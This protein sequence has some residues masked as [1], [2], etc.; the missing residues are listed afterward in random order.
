MIKSEI[1]LARYARSDPPR[2]S[3][4]PPFRDVFVYIDESIPSK[5]ERLPARDE[6][7]PR[8]IRA[9][10]PA[11]SFAGCVESTFFE[12][13]MLIDQPLQ[14]GPRDS[15]DPRL[16]RRD[17]G[18][19]SILAQP[20]N[21][22]RSA[23]IIPDALSSQ[24][25]PRRSSA[26]VDYVNNPDR[27]E[28]SQYSSNLAFEELEGSLCIGFPPITIQEISPTIRGE[29]CGRGRS[30]RDRRTIT[31]VHRPFKIHPPSPIANPHPPI[32]QNSA[33]PAKNTPKAN[34]PRSS[35]TDSPP[36]PQN[37]TDAPRSKPRT[38]DAA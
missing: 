2:A 20:P 25:E 15:L 5:T 12:F 32:S 38:L 21:A 28:C 23:D 14:N 31:T 19:P 11:H 37:Q 26:A 1:H 13:A 4:G 17:P 29:S 27:S 30:S 6:T 3:P 22:Q 35:E 34:T 16:I 8:R 36:R 10:A 18:L 24:T 33:N 9:T 7:P